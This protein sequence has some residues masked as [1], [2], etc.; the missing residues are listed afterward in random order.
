MSNLKKSHMLLKAR[1]SYKSNGH[2]YL[3]RDL[4][5]WFLQ[6]RDRSSPDVFQPGYIKVSTPKISLCFQTCNGLSRTWR[7]AW[8]SKSRTRHWADH[9]EGQ[10]SCLG[11]I[12]QCGCT[13]LTLPQGNGILKV[14]QWDLEQN[15]GLGNSER[16]FCSTGT[17]SFNLA[18]QLLL[19]QEVFPSPPASLMFQ[20]RSNSCVLLEGAT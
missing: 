3:M 14:V 4:I 20:G 9:K 6:K 1:I 18:H 17:P 16:S 2:F 10:N 11:H 19:L 8:S 7:S 5:E 13:F 15:H 12:R